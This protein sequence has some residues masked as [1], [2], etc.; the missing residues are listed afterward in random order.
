MLLKKAN[1]TETLGGIT[2]DNDGQ[3]DWSEALTFANNL[4]NGNCELSDN[5]NAGNWRLPNRFELESLLNLGYFNPALSNTAGTAKWTEGEPFTNVQPSH[6]WSSS[7]DS[8]WKAARW[9]SSASEPSVAPS[10][11]GPERSG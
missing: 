3:L 10:P 8:R 5:S 7:T 6:Y 2:F 1:C 11:S 9:G 4:A